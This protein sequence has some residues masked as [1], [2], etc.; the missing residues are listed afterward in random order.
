MNITGMVPH[1]GQQKIIDGFVIN[2]IKFGVVVSPRQYGKS[3]LGMNS[4]FY[5]LLNNPKSKGAWI[6][7]V[8]K[9]CRKVFEEI[10]NVAYEI[11]VNSNKSELTIEF[12]NGSTLQFLSADRGDTIRGFSF[13]YMVVDEAAF[14]KQEVFEQAVLPTL[15]ALG[16]K[17]LI[18]S[19]PKGKNWFYNYYLKG[20]MGGGD[21]ISFRGYTNENPFVDKEFIAECKKSMP[22]NIFKQEFE[23]EFI[24]SG[25]DVFTNLDKIC[26][27]DEWMEPNRNNEYYAGIDTGISNDYS[28]C[29]IMD[30]MGRVVRIL[31]ITHE[32]LE[33]TAKLF[34][35]LIGRYRVRTAFV[36]T[37][38]PGHGMFELMKK[39]QSSVTKWVTTNENKALGIQQLI[40][41]CEE[42]T[43][44]LPSRQLLP[45]CYEEFQAYTY[46]QLPTGRLQFNAPN[47]MHDDIVMSI[48]FANEARRLGHLKPNKIYIGKW[49]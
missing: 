17:C 42:L 47:G 36:E 4:L 29:T 41:G 24:D 34:A 35:D 31:R 5:W 38:G 49:N 20:S 11:I 48:M 14:I 12:I 45:E 25:N 10:T 33:S 21:F 3:L 44:E 9:Q 22:T 40:R 23:A 2:A 30:A 15:T 7:P 18:I 46:K 19:T 37:N 32:P 6:S 43:L 28:V 16:K 27:I 8:Y 26:V 39:Q 13:H 1:S